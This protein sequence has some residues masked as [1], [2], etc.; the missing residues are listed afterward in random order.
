LILPAGVIPLNIIDIAYKYWEQTNLLPEE[1]QLSQNYPN[2]FNPTTTINFALPEA[3]KVRLEVY[4]ILVQR[5]ITL[6]DGDLE[7]GYHSIRWNGIAANG[8]EVATGVYFYRIRA[9][10]YV[11]SKKMLLLK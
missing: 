5:V 10:D 7:A 3:S 1:Y 2:P 4:N 9:G 11:E 6:V 8:R